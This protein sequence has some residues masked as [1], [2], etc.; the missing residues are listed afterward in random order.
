MK[1]VAK[2]FKNGRSQAVRLPKEFRF[3][4]EEVF[5]WKEDN[6]IILSPKPKSWREFFEDVPLA[7]DDFMTERK[8]PAP[9]ER[10]GI[11]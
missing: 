3:E 10:E 2:L 8:D 1:H 7:S 6:R 5:I 11:F 9:Q 4:G